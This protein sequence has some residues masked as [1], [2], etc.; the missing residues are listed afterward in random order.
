MKSKASKK[1]DRAER[2]M[3]RSSVYKK[4]ANAASN[5]SSAEST[6]NAPAVHTTK[7]SEP[8]AKVV[9]SLPVEAA[10]AEA[11]SASVAQASKD[12]AFAKNKET[13]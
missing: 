1:P 4:K 5:K 12:D 3:Q 10:H 11:S 8:P 7:A 2:L 9:A 13:E 6:G